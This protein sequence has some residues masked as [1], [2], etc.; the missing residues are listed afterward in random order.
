MAWVRATLTSDAVRTS[1]ASQVSRALGQPV[2]IGAVSLV[3]RPRLALSL[4]DVRVGDR[5]QLAITRIDVGAALPA[6][7]SR[8]IQDAS[9]HVSGVRVSLPLPAVALGGSDFSTR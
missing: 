3:V 5:A 1:L 8:R 7:V 2:S 9:V 6:L 4:R